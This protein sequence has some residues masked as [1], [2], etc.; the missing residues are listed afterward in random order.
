LVGSIGFKRG[1]Q[2]S[3][4]NYAVR[5]AKECLNGVQCQL[6]RKGVQE[7]APNRVRY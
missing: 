6:G 4:L 1:T 2:A 7:V 3:H 5:D